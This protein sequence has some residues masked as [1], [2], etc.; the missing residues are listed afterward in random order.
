M[1]SALFKRVHPG[2]LVAAVLLVVFCLPLMVGQ[3]YGGLDHSLVLLGMQ[4][5]LRDGDG[6][7][8]DAAFGG[9]APFLAEPQSGVFYPITWLL[10]PITDPELAASLWSVVHL[11][12]AGWAATLL[13][14]RSGLGKS[15]AMALGFAHVL[16]GTVLN[17]VLHG[18]YLCGAAWTPLVWAAALG[19]FHARSTSRWAP[20][21]LAAGLGLL[22]LAGELQGFAVA[23][24]LVLA[25]AVRARPPLRVLGVVL[26]AGVVGVLLGM[27][28]WL[29]TFGLRD[30]IARSGGL[31]LGNQTLWSLGLPE[32]LGTVWSGVAGPRFSSGATL[33]NLWS[34][35]ADTRMPWNPSPYVGLAV[36]GLGLAAWRSKMARWWA[37]GATLLL[38]MAL[39]SHTPFYGLV[40]TL[41]PPVGLFRYPS[42]YFA[43]ASMALLLGSF[44]VLKHHGHERWPQAVLG[45]LALLSLG[46]I[47]LVALSS[48][49]LTALSDG[50]TFGVRT[51]PGV[52]P[53]PGQWLVQRGLQATALV[54]VLVLVLRKRPAL[55]P[56]VLVADLA[57]AAPVHL[58]TLDR[59]ILDF[60]APRAA[61]GDA[62]EVVLC[63]DPTTPSARLDEPTRDW[64]LAG[65]TLVQWMQ[66]KSDFNQCGGPAAPQHYLSSATSPTVSL[67]R[68]HLGRPDHQIQA[69]TALGCTH[70]STAQATP[71]PIV[72]DDTPRGIAPPV[73]ALPTAL[74]LAM[75][76]RGTLVHEAPEDAVGAAMSADS[77]GMMMGQLD[78]PSD[79]WTGTLP[80]LNAR[81]SIIEN[82]LLHTSFTVDDPA[83]V[84][85]RKPWWPGWTATQ[86]GG[87]LAVL[88]SAGV[89]LAVVVPEAGEV[90]LRYRPPLLGAGLGALALGIFGLLGLAWIGRRSEPAAEA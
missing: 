90:M 55:A 45:A 71:G 31:S 68:D 36:L 19:M 61:L 77:P 7:F 18:A 82:D 30:A 63:T 10:R 9:G 37:L 85:L 27:G 87:E 44:H 12:I 56:W 28:Q 65:V 24:V 41:V 4:C 32:G 16:S 20:V 64:G 14:T 40:Q 69:A 2:L 84:V 46:G 62:P 5:A 50:F 6:L 13:G 74:P 66:R 11:A 70:L 39:G 52:R 1:S 57:L 29:P 43:P 17:L 86:N 38:L 33:F 3:R 76:P 15:A 88:R 54:G 22:L 8:L 81:V 83:V 47:G 89:Q 59:P 25:E 78:D 79:V 60:E 34:G 80:A 48:G 35:S 75:V 58:Q 51:E 67:W 49:E 73:Y 26:G 23:S 42:K 21:E 72:P 53:E